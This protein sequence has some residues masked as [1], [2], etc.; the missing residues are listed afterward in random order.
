MDWTLLI[1]AMVEQREI[2]IPGAT[3]APDSPRKGIPQRIERYPGNNHGVL[4]T[5]VTGDVIFVALPRDAGAVFGNL[6]GESEQQMRD[7]IKQIESQG[8]I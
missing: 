1:T 3:Q 7:A 4:I 6:V 2:E 8:E 5:F